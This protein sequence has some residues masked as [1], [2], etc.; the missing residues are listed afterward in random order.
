MARG[1]MRTRR[2]RAHQGNGSQRSSNESRG[3]RGD[4]AVSAA[5]F[6]ETMRQDVRAD[7]VQALLPPE[8][9][10]PTHGGDGATRV[11]ELDRLRYSG[12]CLSPVRTI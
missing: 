12:M 6:A 10:R 7:T 8:P 3:T 2:A 9:P 11:R 1:L 5:D 4:G